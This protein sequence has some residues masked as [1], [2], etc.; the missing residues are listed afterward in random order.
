MSNEEQPPA[1]AAATTEALS[2]APRRGWPPFEVWVLG[3]MGIFG[4]IGFVVAFGLVMAR[5]TADPQAATE[6]QPVAEPAASSVTFHR[7]R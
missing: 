6:R 1:T 5:T 3:A 2:A 4:L 7:T